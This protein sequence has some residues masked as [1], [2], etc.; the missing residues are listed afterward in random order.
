MSL[1][2]IV[3]SQADDG[4]IIFDDGVQKNN[5]VEIPFSSTINV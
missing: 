2:A 5:I 1:N 3:F 4:T